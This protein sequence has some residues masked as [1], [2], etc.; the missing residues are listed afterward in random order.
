MDRIV[1]RVRTAGTATSVLGR[2][3]DRSTPPNGLGDQREPVEALTARRPDSFAES[4]GRPAA[5]SAS[6]FEIPEALEG[7]T[8][9]PAKRTRLGAMTAVSR[10]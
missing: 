1:R 7:M 5:P 10:G 6:L 8:A 9:L 2:P 4:L 3:H